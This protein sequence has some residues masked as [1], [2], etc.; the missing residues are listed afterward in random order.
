MCFQSIFEI[1]L[2]NFKPREN[3]FQLCCR[4]AKTFPFAV[5]NAIQYS[6]RARFVCKVLYRWRALLLPRTQEG[7]SPKVK[8][9]EEGLPSTYYRSR[10]VQL[11]GVQFQL[12][13]TVVRRGSITEKLIEPVLNRHFFFCFIQTVAQIRSGNPSE[14]D[15]FYLFLSQLVLCDSYILRM[16]RY[17]SYIWERMDF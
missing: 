11:D 13:R 1:F 2:W 6:L 16:K 8:S 14:R 5:E 12:T 15:K 17:R 10:S 4:M 9:S 3:V 7:F